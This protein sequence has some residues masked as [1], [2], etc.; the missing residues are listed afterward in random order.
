MDLSKITT[1][2]SGVIQAAAFRNL[3]RHFS[4]LLSEHGL[5]AMQWYV[6]GTVYD[7]GPEGIK[8]TDLARKLQTGLPFIT[9]VINLLETKDIVFRRSSDTDNRTKFVTL[10]P[11]YQAKLLSIE[12]DLRSKLRAS[13]YTDITPE[14][15]RIYIKVLYQ[16]AA[17]R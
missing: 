1:Y 11:E 17:I 10:N 4:G 16:L 7:A 14:D 9:N 15:L 13:I 12:E 2:Q 6:V 3:S 5:T 8:L